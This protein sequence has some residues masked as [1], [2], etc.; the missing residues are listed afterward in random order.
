VKT[1]LRS[2]YRK[3]GVASRSAALERAVELHLL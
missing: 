3:L 2:I 1:Q